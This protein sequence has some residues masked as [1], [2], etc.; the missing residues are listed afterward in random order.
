MTM[1]GE[2]KPKYIREI[3]EHTGLE[4]VPVSRKDST[5]IAQEYWIM[6]P[7][8]VKLFRVGSHSEDVIGMVSTPDM[9]EIQGISSST[10][11]QRR[12]DK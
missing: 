12:K 4:C 6:S 11:R 5:M 9:Y 3:Q 8:G 7:T 1:S 10:R 2:L